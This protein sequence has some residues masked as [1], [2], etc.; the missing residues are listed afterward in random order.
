MPIISAEPIEKNVYRITINAGC[1]EMQNVTV[2]SDGL[3]SIYYIK[4]GKCINATG[5]IVNVVQNRACPKNS[6]ILFDNSDDNC[7][8]RER[9]HFYRVQSIKDITPNDAY[10][11]A[12]QHGFVGTVE[13]WLESL[14]GENGKTAY[15][16]AVEAGFE[17]SLEEYLDSLKG[18]SAY[19]IALDNGFLGTEEDWLAS[20]N[21]ADGRSAY[22]VA[23]D[24]GFLGT[25]EDWLASL[26]GTE[27][28]SAYQIALD[29]GFLGSQKE[30][31]ESLK[32]PAGLSAYEIA[33]Q[34]GF[35]G[36]EDEWFAK[37]GDVIILNE[38]VNTIK[39]KH[40]TW[41]NSMESEGGDNESQKP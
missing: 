16:L 28:K 20:L 29:N 3:Y 31:L 33:V 39:D 15:E 32:G 34:H 30:W 12:L 1:G 24:N 35:E 7:N 5:R 18:R 21:G 38:T 14:R 27:G 36:T 19:Q 17:G 25:E 37:N 23:V 26:K 22:E 8:S 9:I 41:I 2:S 13:E 40:L 4:D 10:N 6:Y 11:I